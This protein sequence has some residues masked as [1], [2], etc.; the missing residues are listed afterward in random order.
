[1][2]VAVGKRG[3]VETMVGLGFG[4]CGDAAAP[5]AGNPLFVGTGAATGFVMVLSAEI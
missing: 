3:A 1:M 4:A 2:L 5:T